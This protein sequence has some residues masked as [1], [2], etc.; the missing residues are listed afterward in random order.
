MSIAGGFHLAVSRAESVGA[1]ALQVFT[2]NSNRWAAP[3]IGAE[4]AANYKSALSK[5][6]VRAVAAHDSYLINPGAV[7]PA[8][9][10]K[11]REGLADE[12]RRCSVLGI[13]MLNFHPGAHVGAGERDGIARIV[14]SLDIVHQM[15]PGSGVLSVLE[16]TAG[17][18]TVL[19]HTFEQLR[20][21]IDGVADPD[22]MAV[23]I[24]TCHIFAAGYDISTEEGYE[25][26]M[27][28]FDSVIGLGRLRLM[29]LNDSVK[30]LG[31]KVDRH[32]HIGKGMFGTTA[33]RSIMRD[34]R[35][36]DVPKVLETPKEDDLNEDR[37]NLRTLLDLA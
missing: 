3:P 12:I 28:A 2:K 10:A 16:T 17:Q 9:L 23:C 25:K 27:A 21:I 22:R 29:H 20:A 4:E 31:S 35:L 5:S 24:D 8:I 37:E 6:T 7:D 26:T 36:R 30:G 1:T 14:E 34:G 11:S 33:F 13:G 32:A 19:G 18:G 15:T